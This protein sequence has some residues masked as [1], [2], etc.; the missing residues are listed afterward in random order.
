METPDLTSPDI[1]TDY[2]YD[3]DDIDELLEELDW[4]DE[5]VEFHESSEELEDEEDSVE[6]IDMENIC[7]ECGDLS[8]IVI[9][10]IHY[11]EDCYDGLYRNFD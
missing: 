1:Q 11:C 8:T 3:T 10:D 4:I 6:D 9:N 5:D 2:E 7:A